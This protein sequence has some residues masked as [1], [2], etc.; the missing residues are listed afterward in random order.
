MR[1][2]GAT[3]TFWAIGK[4]P[5]ASQCNPSE[6]QA[7]DQLLDKVSV[8][9]LQCLT[10]CD[11]NSY[12]PCSCS[13][14]STPAS[15]FYPQMERPITITSSDDSTARGTSPQ[16]PQPPHTP[17]LGPSDGSPSSPIEPNSPRQLQVPP[18]QHLRPPVPPTAD[19][20]PS[21][22]SI[23]AR[24]PSLSSTHT[25]GRVY[26]FW[27]PR[28]IH[29]WQSVLLNVAFFLSGLACSLAH[30]IFYATL[31]E[32]IVGSPAEQENNLR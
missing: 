22:S 30:C 25:F 32:T 2:A 5:F 14:L 12:Q 10:C 16:P 3:S 18:G 15:H 1:G 27:K 19:R 20:R 26:N 21:Q 7:Q 9:G 28:D 4:R 11:T 17:S 8:F 13:W 23:R 6:D 29:K 31:D 24:L